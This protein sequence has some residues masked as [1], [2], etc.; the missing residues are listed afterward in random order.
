MWPLRQ[1]P[2]SSP[3]PLVPWLAGS[4][5][6]LWAIIAL[7]WLFG[8]I[9]HRLGRPEV[10]GRLSL[11]PKP[12][13]R[14]AR[15]VSAGTGIMFDALWRY[16]F[17][18]VAS[19]ASELKARYARSRFGMLWHVLN[20]L[21]QAA[22]FAVVLSDV[23]GAK[24]PG[25]ADK[26]A[27]P[28]YL[29]SGMAAWTL[30]ADILRRSLTMFIEFAGPLK[31]LAFPRLALPV[32]IIG[33]ALVTHGLLLGAT[34]FVFAFYG[35]FPHWAWLSVLFGMVLI[36]AFAIALGLIL[37]IINVFSRD[38][39][40]LMS[41]VL[42]LWFWVTPVVYPASIVPA[43]LQFLIALN[44]MT[45]LVA[46]YQNALAFDAWPNLLLLVWPLALIGILMLMA[47]VLFR[48]SSA[49]I[50]DAL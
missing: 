30:F 50:V 11:N 16:R 39:A 14:P 8:L 34:F 35:H 15:D 24:L 31:K 23:L 29:L 41:V 37:G 13:L 40:Q 42:Q 32:I 25:V 47:A 45:P 9:K 48:R 43:H 21:A 20:P 3:C 5:S 10:F 19:I 12:L 26:A 49:E 28:L 18:I 27:Y 38:V 17:F 46:I 6:A 7:F 33:N 36:I 1:R 4:S 44:P 2:S 22:I